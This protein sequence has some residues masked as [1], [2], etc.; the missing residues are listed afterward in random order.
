MKIIEVYPLFPL[1]SKISQI[2]KT[3]KIDLIQLQCQLAKQT[4]ATC[5]LTLT[6]TQIYG[7]KFGQTHRYG[8]WGQMIMTCTISWTGALNRFVYD[9]RSRH[10]LNIVIDDTLLLYKWMYSLMS[11]NDELQRLQCVMLQTELIYV[12]EQEQFLQ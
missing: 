12:A 1:H 3:I 9:Y 6:H 7:D 2:K 11:T 8:D 10:K 4:Q 5:T